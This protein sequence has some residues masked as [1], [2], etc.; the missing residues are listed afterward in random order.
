MQTVLNPKLM[1]S[2]FKTDLFQ[3]FGGVAPSE[4]AH[5]AFEH[6]KRAFQI[7]TGPNMKH[8]AYY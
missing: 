8:F 5:F 6:L 3:H 4:T 1:A 7:L 2:G